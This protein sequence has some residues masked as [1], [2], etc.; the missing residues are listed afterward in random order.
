MGWQIDSSSFSLRSRKICKPD[1]LFK[2]LKKHLPHVLYTTTTTMILLLLFYIVVLCLVQLTLGEKLVD[3]WPLPHK[4]EAKSDCQSWATVQPGAL[5]IDIV[6][7]S[8]KVL[9]DAVN[10]TM[11]R[12]FR[13]RGFDLD[14]Y[15]NNIHPV[16]SKP[17]P[18]I[19][20]TDQ[21]KF[22]VCRFEFVLVC[23]SWTMFLICCCCCCC[24]YNVNVKVTKLTIDVKDAN[25]PLSPDVDAQYFLDIKS[26]TVSNNRI[27][28]F[29]CCC[30]CCNPIC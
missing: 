3:I 4:I 21:P 16:Y 12:L 28:L 1:K 24:C 27:C 11:S 19:P 30:C 8:N 23:C 25:I 14:P 6:A 17:W 29:F 7:G 26:S 22:Q 9:V 10:R 18:P 5:H 13:D 20:C 15:R 2:L